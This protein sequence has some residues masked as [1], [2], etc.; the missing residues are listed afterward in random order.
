MRIMVLGSL[1]AAACGC[2]SVQPPKAD[3]AS[4]TSAG[5]PSPAFQIQ[6][7]DTSARLEAGQKVLIDNPYGDV[8]LRFGGYEHHVDVHAVIQQ[9]EG[10]AAITLEPAATETGYRIAP[11]LPEGS[12]LAPTQRVDL[13]VFVAEGHA[14]E[15]RTEQGLIECRSI[16]ADVDLHSTSGNITIRGVRGRIQAETGAGHIEAALRTAPTGSSQKLSTTTGNLIVAVN[17]QLNARLGLAT[18]GLFATEYSLA[19]EQ[20]DGREPNKRAEAVIGEPAASIELASLRGEI[21]LLRW[22]DF[23][24]PDAVPAEAPA[25][26]RTE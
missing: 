17:D 3:P 24:E 20:L 13:V 25:P 22:R 19:V 21:R 14:L 18:S 11:R 12:L 1:L 4:T 9:P 15:V 5:S 23:Q 8:R 6:R 7:V 2:A 26:P 16:R 10:A